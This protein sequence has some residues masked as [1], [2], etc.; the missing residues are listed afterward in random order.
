[1]LPALLC[2]RPPQRKI[3]EPIAYAFFVRLGM[4]ESLV[5]E[6]WRIVWCLAIAPRKTLRGR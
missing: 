5:T 6:G 4:V 2:H 3:E 1:M